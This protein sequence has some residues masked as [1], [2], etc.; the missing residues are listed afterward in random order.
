MQELC[1]KVCSVPQ[2]ALFLWFATRRHAFTAVVSKCPIADVYQICQGTGRECWGSQAAQ[3]CLWSLKM[4]C[5]WVD[6]FWK[7]KPVLQHPDMDN[8]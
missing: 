1:H 3:V 2:K 4:E 5:D 8:S 6:L 7:G